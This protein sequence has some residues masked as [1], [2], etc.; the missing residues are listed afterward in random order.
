MELTIG[1]NLIISLLYHKEIKVYIVYDV[2]NL[3]TGSNK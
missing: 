1:S 2:D 3:Q